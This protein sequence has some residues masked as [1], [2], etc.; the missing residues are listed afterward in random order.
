MKRIT[1]IIFLLLSVIAVNLLIWFAPGAYRHNLGALV[2]KRI[3]LEKKESPKIVLVGGSNLNSLR[4]KYIEAH[5]NKGLKQPYSLVNMGLWAGLHMERYIDIILR[6]L[7]R[8]DI[9]IICQEYGTLLDENFFRYMEENEEGHK[10]FFL[11]DPGLAIDRYLQKHKFFS[12]V[13]M[14][15][16]LNQ[17]KVKSWIG[18]LLKGDSRSLIGGGF[19]L[20]HS[21]Y[22]S[23]GDRRRPFVREGPLAGVGAKMQRPKRNLLLYLSKIKERGQS[24][25][26]ACLFLYPPF[27]QAEFERNRAEINELH[28]LFRA[29]G[30]ALLSSPDETVYAE[31]FFGDSVNHLTSEGESHRSA[32]VLKKLQAY[33]TGY[34]Q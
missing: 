7:H 28:G 10:F 24:K 29:M 17:L 3:M 13:K 33:L 19:F 27:P 9:L 25:G 18:S 31:H 12:I 21:D 22:N 23:S 30:L 2:N 8:G 14:P 1:I 26:V 20:Y 34:S 16:L 15:F 6:Y 32:L 4:S 11:M 5:I